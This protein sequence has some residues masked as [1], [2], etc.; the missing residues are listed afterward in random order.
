MRIANNEQLHFVKFKGQWCNASSIQFNF[1]YYLDGVFSLV[2]DS[3]QNRRNG[4]L[5]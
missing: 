4:L 2:S 1:F 5:Y 3:R